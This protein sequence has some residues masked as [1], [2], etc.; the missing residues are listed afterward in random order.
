[1]IYC[2]P[3]GNPASIVLILG[4]RRNENPTEKQQELF[5]LEALDILLALQH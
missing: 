2:K 5:I 4:A 1:M 3:L